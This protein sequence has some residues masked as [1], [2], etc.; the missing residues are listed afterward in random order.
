[1]FLDARFSFVILSLMLLLLTVGIYS[2]IS[3]FI[4]DCR[5][6]VTEKR[7]DDSVSTGFENENFAIPEDELA[8]IDIVVEN[9]KALDIVKF[10]DITDEEDSEDTIESG[11]RGR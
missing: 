10:I 4:Y 9:P 3:D 11:N 7:E 1:M 2:I 5:A 8:D 6:K